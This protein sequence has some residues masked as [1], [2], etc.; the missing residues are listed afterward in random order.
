M[1]WTNVEKVGLLPWIFSDAD[2]RDP[3]EQANDRYAHGGGWDESWSRKAVDRGDFQ[4]YGWNE[5]GRSVL[6]YMNDDM[7]S[8]KYPKEQYREVSRAFLR[9]WIIVVYEGAWVAMRKGH[10]RHIHLARMD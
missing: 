6:T 10:E 9:E 8:N 7:R 5:L 1:I 3:I 4:F 2:P